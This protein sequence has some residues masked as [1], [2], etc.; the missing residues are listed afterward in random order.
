M[1]SLL[2]MDEITLNATNANCIKILVFTFEIFFSAYLGVLQLL[3]ATDRCSIV[4]LKQ[5]S[6]WIV[7]VR[8]NFKIKITFQK[9]IC[10][11]NIKYVLSIK[12]WRLYGTTKTKNRNVIYT[13]CASPCRPACGNNIYLFIILRFKRICNKYISICDNS[14]NNDLNQSIPNNNRNSYK[15]SH[16]I[17]NN[18]D[19]VL[20]FIIEKIKAT[21]IKL[22]AC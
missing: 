22:I 2:Y 15:N 9:Y 1:A 13:L 16:G 12:K 11:R 10:M 17:L 7:I 3:R 21:L 19:I 5:L 6:N 14:E 20:S 8:S 18:N 4:F